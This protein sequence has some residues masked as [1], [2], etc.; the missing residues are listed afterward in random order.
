M[1]MKVLAK[2]EANGNVCRFLQEIPRKGLMHCASQPSEQILVT[3]SELDIATSHRVKIY[4]VLMSKKMF[5]KQ[6]A[7]AMFADLYKKPVEKD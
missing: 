2:R 7:M 5:I 4:Q 6:E 1:S 3:K